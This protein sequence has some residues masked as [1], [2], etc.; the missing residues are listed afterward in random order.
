[1]PKVR[2][3]KHE[4]RVFGVIIIILFCT[5]D[6]GFIIKIIIIIYCILYSTLT[7]DESRSNIVQYFQSQY[8]ALVRPDAA[9]NRGQTSFARPP[10]S[11]GLNSWR[12]TVS[13]LA[14]L[15]LQLAPEFHCLCSGIEAGEVNPLYADFT[16]SSA[17]PSGAAAMATGA[18]AAG[19]KKSA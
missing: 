17:S 18:D 8:I 3:T 9:A 15:C 10:P 14:C 5:L 6:S 7:L 11:A 16:T 4:L 13:A 1:M 12:S 19:E 2:Y